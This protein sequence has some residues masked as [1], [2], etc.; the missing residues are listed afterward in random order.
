MHTLSLAHSH[1]CARTLTHSLTH[2]LTNARARCLINPQPAGGED[3]SSSDDEDVDVDDMMDA[4]SPSPA[5]VVTD[6]DAPA[7]SGDTVVCPV[8]SDELNPFLESDDD[9]V[10]V[11]AAI[12]AIT[13]QASD[14]SHISA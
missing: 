3:R 14:D 6:D 11:D 13:T 9:D 12:N 1:G 4:V 10:D 5:V 2:T 8:S 7:A